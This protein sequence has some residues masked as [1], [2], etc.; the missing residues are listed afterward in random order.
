[1]N[2]AA[3]KSRLASWIKVG[4][5]LLSAAAAVATIAGLFGFQFGTRQAE[6]SVNVHMTQVL[7]GVSS[8]QRAV[9]APVI[10]IIQ[11]GTQQAIRSGEPADVGA[12]VRAI[13]SL[14]RSEPIGRYVATSN[15]FSLTYEQT[16]FVCPDQ[17]PVTYR[18]RHP[19]ED[20]KHRLAVEG[21][22]HLLDR[23]GRSTHKALTFELIDVR[24]DRPV[25][26]VTCG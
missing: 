20:R 17:I 15:L 21:W 18:G 5:A 14:V 1:M 8:D 11:Q 10:T 24:D 2:E 12:T 26:R 3:P 19:S 22:E 4:V 25:F 9:V 23:G 7:Q 6:Q 13:E 16:A